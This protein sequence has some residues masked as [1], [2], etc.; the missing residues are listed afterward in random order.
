MRSAIRSAAF[1]IFLVLIFLEGIIILSLLGTGH[2]KVDK[3]GLVVKYYIYGTSLPDSQNPANDF[4]PCTR[5][6]ILGDNTTEHRVYI[7]GHNCTDGDICYFQPP[8]NQTHLYP[9]YCCNG[10]CVSN[11]SRCMGVCPTNGLQL[12]NASTCSYAL[13]PLNYLQ[14]QNVSLSCIYGSCTLLTIQ[15]VFA[16]QP[17]TDEDVFNTSHCPRTITYPLS[18]C[19]KYK[20]TVMSNSTVFCV[21]RYRCASFDLGNTLIDSFKTESENDLR[22][23]IFAIQ[24][25]QY[26]SYNNQGSLSSPQYQI[27]T[28]GDHFPIKEYFKMNQEVTQFVQS[29]FNKQ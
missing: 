8:P 16:A 9:K 17:L 23:T 5:D 7:D 19:I 4:N 18:K 22:N 6:I 2:E 26:S 10:V 3:I 13:F 14:F 21:F 29:S 24:S 27:P 1:W 11:R 20:C 12:N 15:N 25:G 28:F